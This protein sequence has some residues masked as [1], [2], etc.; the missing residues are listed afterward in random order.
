MSSINNSSI[1]TRLLKGGAWAAIA[2]LIKSISALVLNIFLARILEPSEL[3]IYFLMLSFAT[4]LSMMASLGMGKSAMRLI[5]ENS[6]TNNKGVIRSIYK[7][8]LMIILI[9]CL[10]ITFTF[11]LSSSFFAKIFSIEYYE[12]WAWLICL[13]F[14]LLAF[15]SYFSDCLRGLRKIINAVFFDGVY[16]SSLL[17]VTLCFFY[18]LDIKIDLHGLIQISILL[19]SI[20]VTAGLLISLTTTNRI[21]LEQ[22]IN[23][24]KVWSVGWPLM[25][26]TLAMINLTESAIIILGI[27][28]STENLALYGIALK[29][30]IV[31]RFSQ[32]VV[33]SVVPPLIAELNATGA[34]IHLEKMLRSCATIVTFIGLIIASTY[35]IYGNILLKILFGNEYVKAYPILMILTLGQLVNL[36]VGSCGQVLMMT[37]HQR[38]LMQISI[39]TLILTITSA[40]IAAKE[41]DVIGVA[42]VFSAS[43][44]FQSLMTVIAVKKKVG[45]WT[46]ALLPTTAVFADFVTLN[47]SRNKNADK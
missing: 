46:C 2:R 30:I 7:V 9:G 1:R 12:N 18:L 22:K 13:W 42:T 19:L 36:G 25:F 34:N 41:F 3:G 39:V 28:S 44:I 43:I 6:A 31:L 37:G 23:V 4:I 11:I 15:Q 10:V 32:F 5:A 40:I 8:S 45:I 27:Y 14:S 38:L 47:K 26:A 20:I 24:T 29:L 17:A 33:N 16:F 35:T 21:P